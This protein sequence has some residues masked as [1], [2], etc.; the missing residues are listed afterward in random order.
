MVPNRICFEPVVF[1]VVV[2][3]M[4]VVGLFV[5]VFIGVVLGCPEGAACTSPGSCETQ[6]L[7]WIA[8]PMDSSGSPKTCG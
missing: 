7:P 8:S 3:D 1:V 4:C 5:G 2:I 6:G